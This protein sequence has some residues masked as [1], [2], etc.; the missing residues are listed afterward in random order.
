MMKAI[1]LLF[2]L[3]G[4]QAGV[5]PF[6]HYDGNGGQNPEAY[7]SDFMITFTGAGHNDSITIPVS[8]D[9]RAVLGSGTVDVIGLPYNG[10]YL[11]NL[12][13]DAGNDGSPEWKYEGTGFGNLG[14]QTTLSNGSGSVSFMVGP[15]KPFI[16]NV[17]LPRSKIDLASILLNVSSKMPSGH[18]ISLRVGNYTWNASSDN[19]LFSSPKPLITAS[20]PPYSMVTMDLRGSALP[21][22]II[23]GKYGEFQTFERTS[24]GYNMSQLDTGLHAIKRTIVA[25]LTGDPALDLAGVSLDQMSNQAT[26]FT[27]E[28]KNKTLLYPSNLFSFYA[29][30]YGIASGDLD[31]NGATDLV[32]TDDNL[33]VQLMNDGNGSFATS[34]G[35]SVCPG[36]ARDVA[37]GELTQDSHPDA[38]AV[39]ENGDVMLVNGTASG[40]S[41]NATKIGFVP[42]EP[43][44]V[45]LGDVTGDGR[46]D[47]VVGNSIGVLGVFKNGGGGS[48]SSPLWLNSG[49]YKITDI[50]IRDVDEDTKQDII[51]TDGVTGTYVFRN[52]GFPNFDTTGFINKNMATLN[53]LSVTDIDGDG[54]LDIVGADADENIY[55]YQSMLSGFELPVDIR[56]GVENVITNSIPKQD[57]WGNPMVNVGIQVSATDP[58]NAS[59]SG[60]DIA[61]NYSAKV[62]ITAS[63]IAYRDGHPGNATGYVNVPLNISTGSAG[64]ALLHVSLT[65]SKMPPYLLS[66][67]PSTYAFAEDTVGKDLIDLEQYFSDDKDDGKLSFSVS[68]EQDPMKLH[69]AVDGHYLTFYPAKHWFGAMGFRATARDSDALSTES[70]TFNVTVY[71][72]NHLPEFRGMPSQLKVAENVTMP[73]DLSPY[74]Y[75]IEDGT[76]LKISTTDPSNITTIG[77]NISIKYSGYNFTKQVYITI[78]DKENGSA[79]MSLD[80][81]VRPYGA[82]VFMPIEPWRTP[83]NV[84]VSASSSPLDLKDHVMDADTSK[85]LLT[86]TVVSQTDQDANVYLAGSKV[87]ISFLKDGV[88]GSTVVH[89][90]VSDGK[91]DDETFL[92]IKFLERIVYLGGL[93]DAFV[94]E[95]STWKVDLAPMFNLKNVSYIANDP[96]I[97][98]NGSAASWTPIQGDASI[99]NLTFMAFDPLNPQN[100]ATTNPIDLTYVERNDPPIYLGGLTGQIVFEGGVWQVDLR[101][102]FTDEEHPEL[103]SFSANTNNVTLNDSVATWRP[104]EGSQTVRGVVFTATDH[105]DAS[106][107]ASSTP[108]DLIYMRVNK[109]PT[110]IIDTI[111]PTTAPKNSKIH[112][113]G[114]GYDPDGNITAYAW[115]S[116]KDGLLSNASEFDSV[117]SLG[118][119]TIT[120]LVRDDKGLWSKA[121]YSNVTVLSSPAG[122]Q[123]LSPE[124]QALIGAMAVGGI[125]ILVG[126]LYLHSRSTGRPRRGG[127]RRAL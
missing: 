96:R 50:V 60:I 61:Y 2:V 29:F 1:C 56:T 90:R 108:I 71:H 87:C 32:V 36:P 63:L 89:L 114:H 19:T 121:A 4:A 35:I 10:S 91:W 79:T 26:I 52:K 20:I 46:P 93:V 72:V 40:L 21:E 14:H 95:D 104:S 44:R 54:D 99:L 22:I 11:S 55:C 102:Y 106:L 42:I 109:Q 23:G 27:M 76:D 112:F 83:A 127:R 66:K 7:T 38:V 18:K 30:P 13:L 48:F 82:P 111:S 101:N 16:A 37:A 67:I 126:G 85:D 12:V 17:T 116:D 49:S 57:V 78:T 77:T 103:L 73:L 51:A 6:S 98:M 105:D 33:L 3:L 110:A 117:L 74:I 5:S 123:G 75:D 119:H 115:R 45:V 8:K 120:F 86:F 80:I 69:T 9:P 58:T 70:N 124:R 113:K 24:N 100:N 47:V 107:Q 92:Q 88:S 118:F 97:I 31:S 25:N 81:I 62:N 125:L 84:N 65:Y 122:E 15:S 34:S 41:A 64:R 43:A 39:C 53:S 59:I 28:N 94:I 68:F